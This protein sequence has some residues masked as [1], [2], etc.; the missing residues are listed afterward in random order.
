MMMDIITISRELG[1]SIACGQKL[2]TQMDCRVFYLFIITRLNV[3]PF[4]D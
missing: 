2:I 3:I 4:T 1:V